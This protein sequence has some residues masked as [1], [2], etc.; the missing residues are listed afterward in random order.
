MKFRSALVTAIS[1]SIGGMTGARNR[2]GMYLR[3]RSQPV[4]PSTEAQQVVR[5]A[6]NELTTAWNNVLTFAQRLDWRIYADNSPLTDSLG[7]PREV[8]ALNMYVR[9][10]VA[11]L[12]AGLSRIDN[13]PI[14]FGIAEAATLLAASVDVGDQEIN[15]TPSY[16]PWANKTGAAMLVYASTPQNPGVEFFK[17]PYRYVGAILGNDTTAPSGAKTFAAPFTYSAGQKVFVRTVITREDGRFG[18]PFRTFAD[19]S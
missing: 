2:G 16:G 15:V 4:N 14:V 1:G 3:A 7:Q 8:T 13:S 6:L 10:N 19:A 11:R 17:G 12:Q 9:G 5:N 18:E